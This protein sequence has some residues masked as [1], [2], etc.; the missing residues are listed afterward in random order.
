MKKISIHRLSFV[1]TAVAIL[2]AC[3]QK[4]DN[5]FCSA[6]EKIITKASEKKL[7]DLKGPEN[8]NKIYGPNFVC[9]VAMPGAIESGLYN[10]AAIEQGLYNYLAVMGFSKGKGVTETAFNKTSK[11]IKDCVAALGLNVDIFDQTD[12]NVTPK[13]PGDKD[14]GFLY[15]NLLIRLIYEFSDIY[16]Q[17]ICT[18]Y[19]I[20]NE[21]ETE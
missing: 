17:Y 4:K 6:F 21:P 13:N 18:L 5:E 19:I 7:V 9:T 14:M 3:T 16:N 12:R 10:A 2:T 15:K 11:Q 1:L 8:N 20:Y